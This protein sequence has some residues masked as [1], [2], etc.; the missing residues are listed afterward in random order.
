MCGSNTTGHLE[1]PGWIPQAPLMLAAAM[2]ALVALTRILDAVA[3][4]SQ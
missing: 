2:L 4:R 1:I 3:G